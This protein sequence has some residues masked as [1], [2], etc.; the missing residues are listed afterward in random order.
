VALVLALGWLLGIANPQPAWMA[1]T[2]AWLVGNL[3]LTVVAE[4]VFFR[5]L[6]QTKLSLLFGRILN[7]IPKGASLHTPITPAYWPALVATA[8]LFTI[9]HAGWGWQF[10]SIAFVASL[11]Y[12]HMFGRQ[13]SLLWAVLAHFLVNAATLLL[14][15]SP[16][17]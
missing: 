5:G 17:G 7:P 1:G 2:G 16:L 10:A 13:A 12:G 4:E 6:L 9:A 15:H 8:L 11:F 3:F 14:M